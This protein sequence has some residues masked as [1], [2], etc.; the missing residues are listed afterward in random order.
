MGLACVNFGLHAVKSVERGVVA[1]RVN[2]WPQFLAKPPAIPDPKILE[3]VRYYHVVNFATRT[4][5][6]GIVTVGFIDTTCPPTSV[7]A[8]YNALPG[9]KK[10]FNDVPSGHALSPKANAA[11]RETIATVKGNHP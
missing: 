10:I 8:A 7:Y 4:K 2:G 11:M 1:G 5:A 3:T 6:A 9:K